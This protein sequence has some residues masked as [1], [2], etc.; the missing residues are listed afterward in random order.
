MAMQ[1]C[2]TCDREGSLQR[3]AG[4]HILQRLVC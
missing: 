4:L 2:D 3:Q 1:R